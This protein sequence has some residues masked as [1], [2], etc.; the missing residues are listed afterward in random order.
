MANKLIYIIIILFIKSILYSNENNTN[1]LKQKVKELK[2]NTSVLFIA[3][4]PTYEDHAL[5]AYFRYELGFKTYLAF[6]TNGESLIE[7][8]N[9]ETPSQFAANLREEA[10]NSSKFLDTRLYFFCL[11]DNAPIPSNET[12]S[13][14]WNKENITS[15]LL[16]L[17][18]KFKPE[19]IILPRDIFYEEKSVTSEYVLNCLLSAIQKETSHILPFIFSYTQ[20]EKGGISLVKEIEKF[21]SKF[22]DFIGRAKDCYESQRQ[23]LFYYNPSPSL[24]IKCVYPDKKTRDLQRLVSNINS[25]IDSGIRQDILNLSANISKNS[26]NIFEN[27]KVRKNVLSKLFMLNHKIDQSLKSKISDKSKY[28]LLRLKNTLEEIR[29]IILEANVDYEI[30]EKILTNSQVTHLNIKNIKSVN[31]NGETQIIFPGVDNGWIVNE[32]KERYYDY[33]FNKFFRIISP[34]RIDYHLPDYMYGIYRSEPNYEFQFTI[35][36][37]NNK[38][39]YSFV[40][41]ENIQ[42]KF[43]PRFSIEIGKSVLAVSK[44]TILMFKLTNNSRDGVL[45]YI[46]VDHPKVKSNK[47]K[48]SLNQKGANIMDTLYLK[49]DDDISENEFSIPVKIGEVVVDSILAKK[50]VVKSQISKPVYYL[51]VNRDS[52]VLR[53][54][55]YMNIYP[56]IIEDFDKITNLKNSIVVVSPGYLSYL[57]EVKVRKLFSE[58]SNKGNYLVVFPQKP[59]LWNKFYEYHNILLNE[60]I[61]INNPTLVYIEYSNKV[62]NYPNK[63]EQGDFIGWVNRIGVN[64]ITLIDT[65]DI[66]KIISIDDIPLILVKNLRDS[67]LIYLNLEISAQFYNINIGACKILA[68]ILAIE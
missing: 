68:N 57:G 5:I 30:D 60:E 19:I 55:N 25:S 65:Q 28:L 40:K 50:V 4:R 26:K 56:E 58:L 1:L 52:K 8:Y 66:D 67:K 47:V 39:E 51:N 31:Y 23:K 54:L 24:I 34:L 35:V 32:S 17:L 59:I 15:Q 38:G 21:E 6:L 14:N 12:I 13:H 29:C 3:I 41:K 43:A 48:F 61:Y 33:K 2:N 62:N 36:H 7:D 22:G 46:F 45:D 64:S 10:F 44:D 37:I 20:S 63:L 42:F 16:I 9:I 53:L 11:P 27:E 18:K 49:W